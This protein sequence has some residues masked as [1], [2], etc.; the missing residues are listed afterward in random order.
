MFSPFFGDILHFH[1]EMSPINDAPITIR[2]KYHI[3]PEI[4]SI[5][6]QFLW[7]TKVKLHNSFWRRGGLVTTST[8][9]ILTSETFASKFVKIMFDWSL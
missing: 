1:D 4:K 5:S 3:S 9:A 2:V 7:W 6:T 8:F